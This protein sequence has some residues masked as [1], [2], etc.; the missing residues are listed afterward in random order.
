M[1]CWV[2]RVTAK[3]VSAFLLLPMTCCALTKHS[4]SLTHLHSTSFRFWPTPTSLPMLQLRTRYDTSE[5]GPVDTVLAW[6]I[7][8]TDIYC[9]CRRLVGYLLL[10]LDWDGPAGRHR[11]AL[12]VFF[13]VLIILSYAVVIVSLWNRESSD[14]VWGSVLRTR[15]AL[16]PG[17]FCLMKLLHALWSMNPCDVLV[18]AITSHSFSCSVPLLEIYTLLV[19]LVTCR[20]SFCGCLHV[21][22]WYFSC[23]I[24][25]DKLCVSYL[26]YWNYCFFCEYL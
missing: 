9:H 8:T 24:A 7:K 5:V 23:I 20:S 19:N 26:M 2:I 15:K 6:C 17:M 1:S 10:P 13:L 14:T 4:A 25:G 18:C 22:S 21:F 12:Y 16:M 3:A 11:V